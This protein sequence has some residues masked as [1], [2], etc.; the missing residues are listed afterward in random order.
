[1]V[2]LQISIYVCPFVDVVTVFCS[3]L[4]SYHIFVL[5]FLFVQ[6]RNKNV[7]T[8]MNIQQIQFMKPFR[9]GSDWEIDSVRSVWQY[10]DK[11]LFRTKQ[12]NMIKKAKTSYWSISMNRNVLS[13]LEI[14]DYFWYTIVMWCV[15]SEH[16]WLK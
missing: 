2:I 14:L 9:H 13:C 1:M 7:T 3:P 6:L 11:F 5:I 4:S 8:F 10:V 12:I 16:L 15:F